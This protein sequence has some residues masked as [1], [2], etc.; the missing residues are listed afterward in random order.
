MHS[1]RWDWITQMCLKIIAQVGWRIT[2]E[3][4]GALYTCWHLAQFMSCI[5]YVLYWLFI[6][7]IHASADASTSRRGTT[8]SSLLAGSVQYLASRDSVECLSSQCVHVKRLCTT[9]VFTDTTM[10]D[11]C[12]GGCWNVHLHHKLAFA[13]T[14]ECCTLTFSA[15][16]LSR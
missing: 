1:S 5:L 16:A 10:G 6:S 12:M 14:V 2:G 13:L 3:S 15:G 4:G 9:Q 8:P 7:S 11:S